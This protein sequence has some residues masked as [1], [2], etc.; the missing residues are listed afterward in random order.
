MTTLQFGVIRC[1]TVW[2][3]SRR[4]ASF[5]DSNHELSQIFCCYSP[6]LAALRTFSAS[7]RSSCSGLCSTSSCEW[8]RA[9]RDPFMARSIQSDMLFLHTIR[10][11]FIYYYPPH[12][13]YAFVTPIDHH[14]GA[15][16]SYNSRIHQPHTSRGQSIGKKLVALFWPSLDDQVHVPS[17]AVGRSRSST[18]TSVSS[19]SD[20]AH[21]G[22][23][24]FLPSMMQKSQVMWTSEYRHAIAISAL[25]VVHFVLSLFITGLLLLVSP[26]YGENDPADPAH[27]GF[28][29]NHSTKL[30]L[31]WA[32]VL[33]LTATA[34]ATV[35]FVPQLW[36]TWNIR[37]VG[38]K[39]CCYDRFMP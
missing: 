5:S 7:F 28:P 22:P 15:N 37:L 20:G 17:D 13:K 3:G 34:L 32:T 18:A 23:P 30:M 1:C 26:K 31:S 39:R 16:A 12:L 36:H 4:I 19:V 8:L 24:V 2:V 29:H 38:C 27:P 6:P 33:G 35:Q 11:L 10:L 14:A 25:V 21:Q 9:S